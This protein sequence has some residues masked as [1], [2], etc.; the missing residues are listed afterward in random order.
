M[1]HGSQDREPTTIATSVIANNLHL[2]TEFFTFTCKVVFV[3]QL[4]QHPLIAA[5]AW[6]PPGA[7]A[8]IM[9]QVT[10]LITLGGRRKEVMVRRVV[11]KIDSA[12]AQLLLMDRP[13]KGL[14]LCERKER[15][16]NDEVEKEK[17][18]LH[19]D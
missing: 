2:L 1:L 10:K 15:R 8:A 17:C 7:V 19:R 4:P 5:V 3:S 14:L 11:G 18:F 9:A 6:Q 12:H 16:N 13:R